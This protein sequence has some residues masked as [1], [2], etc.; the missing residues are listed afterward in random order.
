ML[1]EAGER[2]FAA[3]EGAE[4]LDDEIAIF[5]GRENHAERDFGLGRTERVETP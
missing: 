4:F 5:C 3:F 2:L 1:G